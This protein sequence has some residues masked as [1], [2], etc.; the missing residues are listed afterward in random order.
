MSKEVFIKMRESEYFEIPQHIR[1]SYLTSKNVTIEQNDWELNMQD[2]TYAKLYRQ[3]KAIDKDLKEREY[4]L[5]E[6]RR[7]QK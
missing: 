1:E 4:Q 2:E 7:K 3:K 6:N 5:R